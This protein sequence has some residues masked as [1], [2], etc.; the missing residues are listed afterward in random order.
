[1]E[2]N[3]DF[4]DINDLFLLH[5]KYIGGFDNCDL[6]NRKG[7]VISAI[8]GYLKSQN[9]P[10]IET[11]SNLKVTREDGEKFEEFYLN[12]HISDYYTTKEVSS[13]ELL[14]LF[15]R[16]LSSN[17]DKLVKP[18]LYKKKKYYPKT[19]I[20]RLAK[21]RK[22]SVNA[23][24]LA[25][26]YNF[27][28]VSV[29]V[30]IVNRLQKQGKNVELVPQHKHP[31]GCVHLLRGCDEVIKYI[32]NEKRIKELNDRY[33]EFKIRLS[34]KENLSK[35]TYDT[36]NDFHEFIK[37]RYNVNKQRSLV[38]CHL[39]IY[40]KLATYLQKD[41]IE[42]SGKELEMLIR[43]ME[44]PPSY[45]KELNLFLNFCNT[46]HRKSLLPTT[47]LKKDR[48][49][50]RRSEKH[51]SYSKDEWNNFRILVFS[52]IDKP[53]Y[54]TK[55]LGSRSIA[56]SWLYFALH[57]VT[58]LR[59]KDLQNLPKPDLSVIG[60]TD[61][62]TFLDYLKQGN[63]FTITMGEAI[64][65][66]IHIQMMTYGQTSSKNGVNLRFIVGNSM[67]RQ[68]GLLAALCEAHR[69]VAKSKGANTKQ[70]IPLT[71]KARKFHLQLFGNKYEEIF[72]DKVFSNLRA[73]ATFSREIGD[74]GGSMGIYLFSVL[75][76]HK[77]T[78]GKPS[79]TSANIYMTHG[80]MSEDSDLD[81]IT[82]NLYNRGTF[83]FVPYKIL[84]MLNKKFRKLG[85]QEQSDMIIKLGIT[86][87]QLESMSKTTIQTKSD[88]DFIF[89]RIIQSSK[90]S[91]KSILKRIAYGQSPS[92]H[93]YA[94]CLLRA[95]K[96]SDTPNS[97]L[98]A[99]NDLDY[100]NS[101]ANPASNTCFSCPFLIGEKYFLLELQ[102]KMYQT[103]NKAR[104]AVYERDRNKY[105][106]LLNILKNILKEAMTILGSEVV[107]I[108]ITKEL[109]VEIASFEQSQLIKTINNRT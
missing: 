19:E 73:T 62:Q 103:L 38:I 92:K 33:E 69:Q 83:S 17:L 35:A 86:P 70:L 16:G 41:I 14:G 99:F 26:R 61:G 90:N 44:I 106:D 3:V 10:Y 2:N 60:F 39:Y 64:C 54:L 98:T 46:K 32:E 31:F 95:I 40:E 93:H 45:D 101:C 12:F 36:L 49:K 15:S 8:K 79:Q 66:D 9:I 100:K 76:G 58:A 27:S 53:E 88:I 109:R 102:E 71:Y 82:F 34:D 87:Y 47:K 104:L 23:I 7:R 56:V 11:E 48:T 105:C 18:A 50:Q 89:N 67:V 84:F 107:N 65:K 43:S 94:Q 77:S 108:Y 59:A 72:K 52:S 42:Y 75:R 13:D 55:A 81:A 57:F 30:N 80:Y 85:Y 63:E 24:E 25:K 21:L 1:M 74:E 6:K 28:S 96:A 22:E 78:L 4:L 68:I 20:D 5:K 29:I 91:I 37:E 97:L 51:E